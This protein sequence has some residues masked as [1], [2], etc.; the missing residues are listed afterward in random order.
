M[1]ASP[2]STV[3]D[4]GRGPFR[5]FGVPQSGP[6]DEWSHAVANV[7]VGNEPDAAAL[8]IGFGRSEFR[9]LRR[10][11]IA[12]TGARA[13]LSVAGAATPSWR[14]VAVA[15]G[16]RLL[17]DA[18]QRGVRCYLAVAGGLRGQSVLG[19]R[20]GLVGAPGFP[21][22]IARG[23]RLEVAAPNPDEFA[24]LKFPLRG[25]A[26][27]AAPWWA[28]GEPLLDLDAHAGIRVLDGAHAGLLVDR[29]ALYTGRFHPSSDANRMAMPLHG[30][31]IEVRDGAGLISEPV[32]PGTIQLPPSG[33]PVVLL[34]DA[35][36]VGGYPRIAHVARVDLARLAQR[37]SGAL[38]RF[39][40]ISVDAAQRLWLW[41]RE[42][43]MRLKLV[44]LQR[45]RSPVRRR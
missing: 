4:A 8:E 23:D 43:L 19:S 31:L 13:P 5:P 18:P 32:V 39:E 15:A 24:G 36:T 3:Q 29:H 37:P 17:V 35:Q 26:A 25:G 12:V 33:R 44:A 10:C 9:F 42:R 11:V 40:P 20:S 21:R 34:H 6:L 2:L 7:L 16:T 27:L 45:L 28:D 38:L 14:P 41:R 1:R 22:A 30:S